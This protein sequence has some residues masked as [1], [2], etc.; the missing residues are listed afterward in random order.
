MFKRY[1]LRSGFATLSEFGNTLADEGLI[2]EN[3]LFSHWQNGTRVPK[4]RNTILTLI[5]LLIKNGGINKLNEANNFLESAGQGYLTNNETQLLTPY[6]KI[7]DSENEISLETLADSTDKLWNLENQ[8]NKSYTMIYEGKP[9]EAYS[10]LDS[11]IK[12]IQRLNLDN[13]KE[14]NRLLGLAL[15]VKIRCLTDISTPKT[16]YTALLRAKKY[17]SFS[18]EKDTSE[19]GPSYWTESAILRLH[20]I[21]QNPNQI[22]PQKTR[23]CLRLGE[24][25]LAHTPKERITERI[26]EHIEIGKIALMLNDR[27]LF[28]IHFHSALLLI[29]ELPKTMNYFATLVW[30]L[31]ARADLRFDKDVDGAFESIQEA[32]LYSEKSLKA[33]YLYL[34]N[35]ELQ[36]LRLS[37]DPAFL[38]RIEVLKK[39]LT[40]EVKKS[41]NP[42]QAIR[43]HQS[44]FTGL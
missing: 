4:D 16:F 19:I 15:W 14:S 26:V 21:I 33:I 5:K 28:E 41:N 37:S 44:E 38:R 31:K 12:L 9:S 43:F 10:K 42:Y 25:A 30:D 29:G 20:L 6:I 34:G 24:L 2:F 22:T 1:R 13:S 17:L 18:L 36:A 3:S 8:I 27:S 7:K 40:S 11:I 23:L 35:T 32:K 39:Q